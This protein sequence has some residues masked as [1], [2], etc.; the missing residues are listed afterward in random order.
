MQT[1]CH[2]STITGAEITSAS[3]PLSQ[4]WYAVRPALFFT[5]ATLIGLLGVMVTCPELVD[6]TLIAVL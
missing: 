4:P 6:H 5:L 3:V 2:S 1:N